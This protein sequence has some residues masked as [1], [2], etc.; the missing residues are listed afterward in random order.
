M[1]TLDEIGEKWNPLCINSVVLPEV[2]RAQ[3][4]C[5]V[6]KL[7]S[8]I[9][10]YLFTLQS[11]IYAL[12]KHDKCSREEAEE[13]FESSSMKVEKS[14]NEESTREMQTLENI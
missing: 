10:I 12:Q 2:S 9:L 8:S 13:Y 7:S 1:N 11:V 6:F 3:I 4:G 5:I 14:Y